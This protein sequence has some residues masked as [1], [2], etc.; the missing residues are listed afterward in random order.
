V[1]TPHELASIVRGIS[2]DRFALRRHFGRPDWWAHPALRLTEVHRRA[3][4]DALSRVAGRD[5]PVTAGR[6]VAELPFGFWVGLLGRGRNYEMTLW[7]P[8]L[9]RAFPGYA[10]VRSDLHL[11]LDRLRTF[12]NRIAHHEP[13]FHRHLTADNREILRVIGLICSP[14][15]TWTAERSRVPGVLRARPRLDAPVAET[16]SF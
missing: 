15:R 4:E 2:T 13:V 10:G 11:T 1:V 12:R 14:T 9:R 6:V 7:R 16:T 5:R 8:A 3:V